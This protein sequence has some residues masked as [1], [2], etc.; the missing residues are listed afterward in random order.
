LKIEFNNCKE[1]YQK[2]QDEIS[3]TKLNETFINPISKSDYKFRKSIIKLEKDQNNIVNTT[4]KTTYIDKETKMSSSFDDKFDNSKEIK[5]FK[6]RQNYDWIRKDIQRTFHDEEFKRIDGEEKLSRIL[7]AI[8]FFIDEIGYVQGMNFI[9]GALLVLF[10]NE[11][12]VFF[13]FYV[14]LKKYDLIHLYKKV[15]LFIFF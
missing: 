7:E 10:K 14:F 13:V 3:K 9:A 4:P 6:F 2:I 8:S 12:E 11:E 15:I 5:I 1:L